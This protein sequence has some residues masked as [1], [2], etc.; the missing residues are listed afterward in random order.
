[1]PDLSVATSQLQLIILEKE[2]FQSE[3]KEALS[4]I[5]L[6]KT[7]NSA[8]QSQERKLQGIIHVHV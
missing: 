1:M 3:L 7:K 5:K 8:L 4:E 2:S 6:L